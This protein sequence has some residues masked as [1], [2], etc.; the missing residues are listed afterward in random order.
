LQRYVLEHERPRFLT[1]SHDKI[2]GG[3]YAGKATVHKLLHAGLWWLTIHKDSN[4]YF[5]RCD[6]CQR[7]GKPKKGTRC[8][9][10]HR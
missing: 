5:H 9:F 8:H 7:L 3:H 6:V 1:K 2:V 10:N 4:D